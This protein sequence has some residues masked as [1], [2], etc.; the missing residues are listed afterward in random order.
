MVATQREIAFLEPKPDAIVQSSAFE[1][2][3]KALAPIAAKAE[4]EE[5]GKPSLLLTKEEGCTP[6][7]KIEYKPDQ[8]IE[9]LCATPLR[10]AQPDKPA[11]QQ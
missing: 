1:Q 6:P 7:N 5:V 8:P 4:E 3:K 9:E 10:S 2:M 11:K